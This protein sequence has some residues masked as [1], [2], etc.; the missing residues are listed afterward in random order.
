MERY[1]NAKRLSKLVN[2]HLNEEISIK[3]LALIHG[4]TEQAIKVQ[5][6]RAILLL[7]E[8]PTSFNQLDY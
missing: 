7:Q 6:D 4:K 1:W 3:E 5:I 2:L 8:Y